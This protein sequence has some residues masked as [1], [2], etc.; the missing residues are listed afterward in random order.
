M[1]ISHGL[2]FALLERVQ[3]RRFDVDPLVVLAALLVGERAAQ[4]SLWI[5]FVI[6]H[7]RTEDASCSLSR[8]SYCDLLGDF[9][10]SWEDEM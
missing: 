1:A 6:D 10:S 2:V 7:L 9:R 8:P 3:G 5:L 4:A